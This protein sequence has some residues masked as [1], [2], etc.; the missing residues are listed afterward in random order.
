MELPK[1]MELL[2]RGDINLR[3]RGFYIG[4]HCLGELGEVL[5]KHADKSTC[6]LVKFLLVGPCPLWIEQICVDARHGGRHRKA[7]ILVGVELDVFQ[8]AVE[9]AGDKRT[10]HLDWHA[11]ADTIDATGPTR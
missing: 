6:G 10:R 2:F 1:E 7:E 9:R 5:L 3:S 8:R 4:V 11:R